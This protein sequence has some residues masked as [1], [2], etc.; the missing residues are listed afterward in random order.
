MLIVDWSISAWLRDG[1][2]LINVMICTDVSRVGCITRAC[3]V[4]G[5]HWQKRVH[6]WCPLKPLYCFKL[7]EVLTQKVQ[8]PVLHIGLWKC[9][10]HPAPSY[11]LKG[12][13]LICYIT[14][15]DPMGAGISANQ[16]WCDQLAKIH[17]GWHGLEK[18]TQSNAGHLDQ[19]I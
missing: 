13:S 8:G 2:H 9:G 18:K 4:G 5:M 17:L 14:S 1:F 3:M 15:L 12:K 7:H 16:G 10:T 6:L 11:C 19:L